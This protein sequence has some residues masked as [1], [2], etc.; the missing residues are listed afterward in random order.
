MR[1]GHM[2]II[3][4]QS[5]HPALTEAP[6]HLG[7]HTPVM[8]RLCHRKSVIHAAPS[9]ESAIHEFGLP[10][11]ERESGF[12]PRALPFVKQIRAVNLGAGMRSGIVRPKC[13]RDAAK[14]DLGRAQID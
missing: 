4:A 13:A 10:L 9:L 3:S 1:V 7:I 11:H 5:G 14:N 2:E 8:E 12:R 6:Y